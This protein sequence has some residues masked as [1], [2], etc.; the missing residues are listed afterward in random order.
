VA[1]FREQK[2]GY[3]EAVNVAQSETDA[4]VTTMFGRY[5]PGYDGTARESSAPCSSLANHNTL[6]PSSPCMRTDPQGCWRNPP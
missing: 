4:V 2:K 1:A 3:F 5:D 6:N